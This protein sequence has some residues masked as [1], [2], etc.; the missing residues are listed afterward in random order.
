MFQVV[1]QLK[2]LTRMLRELNR[3]D[4][5]DI[6]NFEEEARLKLELNQQSLHKDPMNEIFQVKE[7]EDINEYMEIHNNYLSFLR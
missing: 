1:A 5:A 3:S 7:R 6:K 2:E 4:F